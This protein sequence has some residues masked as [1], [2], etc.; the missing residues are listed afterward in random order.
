[1]VLQ[2]HTLTPTFGFFLLSVCFSRKK[3]LS[4]MGIKVGAGD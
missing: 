3:L 4:D 1:V 2:P